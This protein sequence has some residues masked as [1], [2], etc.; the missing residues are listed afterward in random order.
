M[1]EFDFSPLFRSAIGFDRTMDLLQQ[2]QDGAAG[3][4]Y[5][6]YDIQK[7]GEDGYRLT[8]AVAGFGPDEL[9]VTQEQ[10]VLRVSG[11]KAAQPLAEYLHRGIPTDAFQRRFEL[12]DYVKVT[13]AD[14]D[15]GL[16]SI[17]LV[18]EVPE[19]MKPRRIA[20]GASESAT[21]P[22]QIKAA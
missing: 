8:L 7:T 6:P 3:E 22:R 10:N 21:P 9:Q 16:L 14:L 19:E 11:R 15:A 20:I 17:E 2:A 4:N 1:R 5:P 12:A 13:S 18:R